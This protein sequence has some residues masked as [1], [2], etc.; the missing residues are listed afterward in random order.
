M[1]A[2]SNAAVAM[3]FTFMVL[4]GLGTWPAAGQEATKAHIF[5]R[6]ALS[7]DVIA[8]AYAGDLWTVPRAGGRATR[9]TAGVGIETSPVFS[10]DGSTI[11]FTGEYDG[12]TDVFTIPVTGGVPFRVTY[13]P[14]A[15]TAVGWTPDGKQILFRSDRTA[16]SRYTQL[17]TVP[18]RG[19]VAKMLPLPMAYQGQYSPDGGQIA[20][21][22]LAP[23]FGFNYTSY[24]AWG[25]YHGGRAS[26]IWLTTLPGLESV[27][28]PHETAS[29]FS[30]VYAGGKIYFLSGRAGATTIFRYDP[31]TKQVS[32][33]LHNDGADI[34]TLAG[35]GN[36]L[37]Y[38]QRGE[39]HLFDTASG[40]SQTVAIEMDA[41]LPEVRSRIQSVA[42]EIDHAAISPTGVRAAF[43]AHGEILTVAA[44]HGPTR[45]ITGTPG[46]MERWPAWSPDGQSIAYFSDESG[47]YALHVAPQMGALVPGGAVKRFPLA[48][49]PAYYFDPLWSPDSKRI[50]FHDN[51]LRI[52]VLDTTTGKLSVVFDQNIYGGFSSRASSSHGHRIRSG[53]RMSGRS[54]TI[55]MG[56]FSTRWI[57]GNRRR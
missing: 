8:F 38:D 20:Y 39:I 15:D 13:H 50:A 30:P 56:S 4:C 52:W 19:G 3:L 16:V 18:A 35:E 1:R 14:A 32:E 22:P 40:K 48:N 5:Q 11:A 17:F 27:E 6:P 33:A 29:D 24:V 12:N 9:L 42:E 45:D 55:C 7:H 47:L 21:S 26:T 41:D 10:P 36:T 51:H 46:V 2:S 37:V 57:R 53:W 44:K 23:A 49:E 34:R 25:N 54:R 31:A 28:I 43:E